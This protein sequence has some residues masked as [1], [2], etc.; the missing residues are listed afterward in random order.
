MKNAHRALLTFLMAVACFVH[1]GEQTRSIEVQHIGRS[2][3][4][5]EFERILQRSYNQLVVIDFYSDRCGPCKMQAKEINKVVKS[6]QSSS[7]AN[8]PVLIVKIKLNRGHPFTKKRFAPGGKIIKNV[9][10]IAFLKNG[11]VIYHTTG[12]TK[13]SQLLALITKHNS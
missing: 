13:V 9:P 7:E 1:A 3:K 5:G 2:L 8:E 6:L 10:Y 11:H 12:L 4:K